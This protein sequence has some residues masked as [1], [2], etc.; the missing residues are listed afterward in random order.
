MHLSNTLDT[1]GR[2]L[3]GLYLSLEYPSPFLKTGVILACFNTNVNSEL[4][5]YV[6]KIE[7]KKL[8]KISAFSLMILEGI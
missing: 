2:I 5:T 1:L 7:C 6:L 8:A 4:V 3:A